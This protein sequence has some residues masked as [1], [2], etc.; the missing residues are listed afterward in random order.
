M[1]NRDHRGAGRARRSG[2]AAIGPR[3][4]INDITGVA[5]IDTSG[6]YL[7]TACWPAPARQA[8][9]RPLRPTTSATARFWQPLT[10]TADRPPRRQ[11]AMA[12]WRHALETLGRWGYAVARD[13]GDILR[14]LAR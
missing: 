9:A 2:H 12:L 5:P 4:A 14:L 8:A 10:T 7:L 11:P 13:G 3:S 1:D 6:A